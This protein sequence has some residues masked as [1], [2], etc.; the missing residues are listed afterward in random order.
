MSTSPTT[1]PVSTPPTSATNGS[2]ESHDA[3][4][5]GKSPTKRGLLQRPIAILVIST[6][7][8]V[9]SFYGLRALS[10]SHAYETTDDAF[11]EGHIVSIS[12]RVAGQISAVHIVENQEVKKGDLLVEIDP[13]DY[14]LARRL[15]EADVETAKTNRETAKS[16]LL[17]IRTKVH[18]AQATRDQNKAEAEAAEATAKRAQADYQRAEELRQRKVTSPQEYDAASAASETAV[19][20]LA[21]AKQKLS[22]AESGVAEAQAQVDAAQ[23][24]VDAAN[25][26]VEQAQLQLEQAEL[27]LSYTKIT[28]P[29][30]GR[31]TRKSAEPGA[32]V[33]VGQNLLAV[34]PRHVWVVANFKETQLTKMRPKQPVEL[35]ISAYPDHT[36]H[37]HVES[38][39]AGSGARFSLLPPENATGNF[40]KVVQ[41]V[42]VRIV[43]DD[44]PADLA[45]IGPGMSVE[46]EVKVDGEIAFP[47]I[48]GGALG[49]GVLTG[50]L[51]FA[52]ARKA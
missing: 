38:F 29:E 25:V 47:L 4:S 21:A 52:R 33:Q 7:V 5:T 27:Q 48:V 9:G 23:T 49:L 51:L 35:R 42:P 46:P 2:Q 6:L 19:Q 40:V 10:R 14:E 44:S 32:Y 34:V 30:D 3:R 43:F 20:N 39:Q 15:R 18:T 8:G 37:G 26:K 36:F 31:V 24:Y 50:I 16:G 28:A 45:V 13:K 1:A 11:T 12:P 17:L 41:R 22:S